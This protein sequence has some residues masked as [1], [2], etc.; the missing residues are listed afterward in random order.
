MY[1]LIITKNAYEYLNGDA[2]A[3]RWQRKAVFC[4]SRSTESKSKN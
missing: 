1:T 4:C 2:E 3:G